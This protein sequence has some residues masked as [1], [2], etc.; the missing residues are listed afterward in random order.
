MIFLSVTVGENLP[1]PV[2]WVIKP[3]FSVVYILIDC[4]TFMPFYQF[5]G[6]DGTPT[7]YYFEWFFCFDI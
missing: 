1:I 6:G 7:W 5:E 3:L 2:D 4:L